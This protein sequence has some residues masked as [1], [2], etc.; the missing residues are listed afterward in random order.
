MMMVTMVIIMRVG[1]KLLIVIRSKRLTVHMDIRVFILKIPTHNHRIE[2]YRCLGR[3]IFGESLGRRIFFFVI[4]ARSAVIDSDGEVVVDE[5]RDQFVELGG[6]CHSGATVTLIVIDIAILLVFEIVRDSG[7]V[8][9]LQ[10]T[11]N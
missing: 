11:I 9:D 10:Q 2:M 8:V 1:I 5:Q 6:P 3:A 4:T 7:V